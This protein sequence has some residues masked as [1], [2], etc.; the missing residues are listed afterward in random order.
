MDTSSPRQLLPVA[1]ARFT[2]AVH[3]VSADRWSHSTPCTEWTVRDVVN[4]LTGEHLWVPHLLRQETVEQVG[5]RYD[6]DVLGDDP[7]AAWDAAIGASLAAWAS[8]AS[9]DLPVHLSYGD[10]PAGEYAADML[11]DLTVH[12][13][14]LAR[15]AGIDERLDPGSVAAVLEH[16][17]PH[18]QMLAGSG[19]FAPPVEIST[20]DPQEELIAL[21]GRDPR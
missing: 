1:A 7:V 10:Q 20:D 21:F 8:L 16:V 9:D 12:A 5:D 4:H 2:E 3:A 6:G 13:W 14:D 19:M 15:G 11:S 18:A 17:R